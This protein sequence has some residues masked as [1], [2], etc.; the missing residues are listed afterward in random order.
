M[1]A[2]EAP[3]DAFLGMATKVTLLLRFP[4]DR[5]GGEEVTNW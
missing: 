4:L 2:K 3:Q 1:W 5:I